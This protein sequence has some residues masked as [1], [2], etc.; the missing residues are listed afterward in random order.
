[1]KL[2]QNRYC[3]PRERVGPIDM[4]QEPGRLAREKWLNLY[5]VLYK[6]KIMELKPQ[7]QTQSMPFYTICFFLSALWNIYS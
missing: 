4:V 5:I 7:L 3:L 2:Y 6:R 1:M